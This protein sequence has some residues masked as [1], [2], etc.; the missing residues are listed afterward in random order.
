M[1]KT[2]RGRHL[3]AALIA[4]GFVA[5]PVYLFA[6]DKGKPSGNKSPI[7][8]KDGK[9][10][11][12]DHET[13]NKG[14]E[15]REHGEREAKDSGK[16]GNRPDFKEPKEP[17][18]PAHSCDKDRCFDRADRTAL[19]EIKRR[20]MAIRDRG[21]AGE[22]DFAEL[23]AAVKKHGDKKICPE[24]YKRIRQ[25]LGEDCKRR[26]AERREHEIRGEKKD[27]PKPPQHAC[28][29]D[30]CRMCRDF[31]ERMMREMRERKEREAAE[32]RRNHGDGRPCTCHP[33]KH[34][35]GP[36]GEAL[37]DGADH[38]GEHGNNGIGN[39]EDPQPPGEPPVNDGSGTRPGTPGN[40]GGRPAGGPLGRR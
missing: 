8:K 10:C 21:E 29:G 5:L 13:G 37:G 20:C 17:R 6:E 33:G 40:R 27:A 39:G 4:M 9:E 12:K 30:G 14:P 38:D 18:R 35:G 36:D 24:L 28:K 16:D 1:S 31:K 3:A 19:E 15:D 11:D 26:M 2:L 22:K 23:D 7:V 25:E 32:H 34:P